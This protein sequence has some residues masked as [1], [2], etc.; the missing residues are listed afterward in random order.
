[1]QPTHDMDQHHTLVDDVLH[2]ATVQVCEE[3]SALL[4]G[5]LQVTLEKGLLL[6]KRQ[7]LEKMQGKQVMA[8]LTVTGE[9]GTQDAY[10]SVPL[11]TAVYLG[12][13]LIMLPMMALDEMVAAD[14]YD[15]DV[16]DAYSEIVEI[17]AAGYTA[18]FAQQYPGKP[19]LVKTA[20][21]PV[22]PAEIDPE[23]DDLVARQT[24]YCIQGHLQYNEHDI[25]ELHFLLPAGVVG[26]AEERLF[27]GQQEPF[28]DEQVQ[29]PEHDDVSG[30]VNGTVP[31]STLQSGVDASSADILLVTDDAQGAEHMA[32]ILAEMGFSCRL[33]SFKDPI[34][35]VPSAEVQLIFLVMREPSEQAFGAAIKISATGLSVPMVAAGPVWTRSLVLKAVKYGA[36]DIL[37]TPAS[38]GDIR[39]IL[40]VNLVKKLSEPA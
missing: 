25:G 39:E 1:M 2:G 3:V 22:S 31:T 32:A 9:E 34:N 14:T 23:A 30:T 7:C 33:L 35:S 16:Q 18:V 27:A 37:I 13:A 10:F 11:K 4:S 8:R 40:A 20:V 5:S 28:G 24:Y 36:C 15:D 6:N 26:L 29:H 17:I 21:E 12:G 19:E 38:A